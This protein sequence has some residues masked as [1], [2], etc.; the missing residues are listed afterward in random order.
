LNLLSNPTSF[1][2]TT[3]DYI[4]PATTTYQG[5]S[6]TYYGGASSNYHPHV[7]NK[8][9]VYGGQSVTQGYSI[10]TNYTAVHVENQKNVTYGANH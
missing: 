4:Q 2:Y 3:G 7:E 5:T 10:P 8:E 1:G 9:F 6:T